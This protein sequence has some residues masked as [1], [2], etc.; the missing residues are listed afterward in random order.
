MSQVWIAARV[1]A[2][3]VIA[4]DVRLI[5][6]RPE[7]DGAVGRNWSPG[8][9]IDV[10]LPIGGPDTVRSYSLIGRGPVA[11]GWRI[12]VKRLDHSRGGSRYM[13]ALKPGDPITVSEPASHFDLRQGRSDYLLIAG[14]IGV[15]PLVG[16][17]EILADVGASV[18][19]VY[20]ARSQAHMAF[21]DHLSKILGQRLQLFAGDQ[22][23][24]L[25]I[26]AEL[27]ALHP[28]GE[29][30]ICGPVPLMEAVQA[31]WK[32]AG[33]PA[34]RLRRET[35]G[36][37]GRRPAEPFDVV[38]R[39]H[40]RRITVSADESLLDALVAAGVDVAS[41]CRRGE[42]GLCTVRVLEV[43]GAL[44]HRDVFLSEHQKTTGG[45]ICACVSRGIGLMTIDTG[46]RSELDAL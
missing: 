41:D 17:A 3:D 13:H 19:M 35:F 7:R 1:T 18:R 40:G 32:A 25:D 29:A 39:D 30:Y 8:A 36:S 4:E 44:D 21:T 23:Q 11:G 15:T 46:Y 10:D 33:R 9:H 27:G 5:T 37:S 42:C 2:I 12:A 6:I 28:D 24:R 22:G 43:E 26:D 34:D 14:G 20:A 38:V 45:E 16:M 31:A